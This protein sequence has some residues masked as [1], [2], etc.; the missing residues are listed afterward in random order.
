M[1]LADQ[2]LPVLLLHTAL[3]RTQLRVASHARAA[4]DEGSCVAWVVQD[5]QHPRVVDQTPQQI[6]LAN[7]ATDAPREQHLLSAQTSHHGAGRA[8]GLEGFEQ[9]PNGVLDLAVGIENDTAGAVVHQSDR[10]RHL[11]LTAA[12]LVQDTAL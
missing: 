6:A 5:L 12:R 1:S 8:G 3:H 7:P 2:H 11:Q 10:Q 4:V 9:Q